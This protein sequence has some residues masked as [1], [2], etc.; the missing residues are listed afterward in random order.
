MKKREMVRRQWATV[1]AECR[2]S[3]LSQARFC[4]QAG[5]GLAALRYWL[6][7]IPREPTAARERDTHMRFIP[8]TLGEA[9]LPG[10]IRH[11]D[12][13]IGRVR[14]RAAEGTDPNYVA[15]LV[16]ALCGERSC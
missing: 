12:I 3:N 4:E 10:P 2:R 9:S 7:R 15:R 11:V 1:V 8:L 6:A 14:V 5:V 16:Q 13:E